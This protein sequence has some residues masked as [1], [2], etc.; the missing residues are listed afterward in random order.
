MSEALSSRTYNSK[1]LSN[2]T[3]TR[4]PKFN[5]FKATY[6]QHLNNSNSKSPIRQNITPNKIAIK[7]PKLLPPLTKSKFIDLDIQAKYEEI[8]AFFKNN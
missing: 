3:P 4:S 5:L 8:K 6:L 2:T 7:R 1:R